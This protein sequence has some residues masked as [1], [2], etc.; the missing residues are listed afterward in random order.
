MSLRLLLGDLARA[1]PGQRVGPFV[2]F[3]RS[4]SREGLKFFPGKL[5]ACAAR[6]T[7]T[8]VT[9]TTAPPP[10][11]SRRCGRRLDMNV[12]ARA[13]A[14][15]TSM[16]AVAAGQRR[17]GSAGAHRRG[18]GSAPDRSFR[19]GRQRCRGRGPAPVRRDA[20]RSGPDT[21]VPDRL[22]GRRP[23][24]R[25]PTGHWPSANRSSAASRWLITRWLA[26]GRLATG[27]PVTGRRLAARRR[28]LAG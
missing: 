2:L 19:R 18:R 15:T 11:G 12:L 27:R 17:P 10:G 20:A 9:T 3:G 28:P 25:R 8:A 7:P 22:G 14:I 1:P 24:S 26:T 6:R 5:L 4:R 13:S 23:T 16:L 21:P